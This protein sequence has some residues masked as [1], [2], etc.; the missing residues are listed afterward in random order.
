MIQTPPKV[1]TEEIVQTPPKAEPKQE[2]INTDMASSMQNLVRYKLA[3]H[4]YAHMIQIEKRVRKAK[5]AKI[6]E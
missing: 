1:D 5:Q 6:D 4:M 2:S 3:C